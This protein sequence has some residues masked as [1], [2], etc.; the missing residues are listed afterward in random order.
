[1]SAW[2]WPTRFLWRS[3]ATGPKHQVSQTALGKQLGMNQPAIARLEAGEHNPSFETLC[4]LSSALGIE[5]LVDIAPTGQK[6]RWVSKDAERSGERID[7][8][9]SQVLIAAAS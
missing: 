1:M 8:E 9:G 5:F 6:R 3:F 7:V 4:R 2:H